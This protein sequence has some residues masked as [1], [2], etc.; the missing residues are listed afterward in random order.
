MEWHGLSWIIMEIFLFFLFVD[1]T[2]YP[3]IDISS[4]SGEL[5]QEIAAA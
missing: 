2:N 5:I 4:G 1:W 3:R